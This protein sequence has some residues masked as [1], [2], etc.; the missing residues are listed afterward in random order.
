MWTT[1]ARVIFAD[2][3]FDTS[4]EILA[5]RAN[6]SHGRNWMLTRSSKCFVT[7]WIPHLTLKYDTTME[8][9]AT[10]HVS[11][12]GQH[13]LRQARGKTRVSEQNFPCGP[14]RSSHVSGHLIF[15]SYLYIFLNHNFGSKC[16]FKKKPNI[17]ENRLAA[18]NPGNYGITMKLI[19]WPFIV[20]SWL[21]F[22]GY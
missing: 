17:N 9:T 18:E 2:S 3:H 22:I 16:N 12:I 5:S 4:S 14:E 20:I 8:T 13:R 19:C 21:M 1:P 11:P 10:R 6:F 7:C 15:H